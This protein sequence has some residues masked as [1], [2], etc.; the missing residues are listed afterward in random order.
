MS[1]ASCLGLMDEIFDC[2]LL[3]MAEI[4]TTVRLPKSALDQISRK[5]RVIIDGKEMPLHKESYLGLW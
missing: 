3:N 5:L 4:P 1:R 2:A